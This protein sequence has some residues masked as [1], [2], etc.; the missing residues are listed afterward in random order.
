MYVLPTYTKKVDFSNMTKAKCSKE[1]A[2]VVKQ[3]PN[4]VRASV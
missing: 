4:R 3:A 2:C 1:G